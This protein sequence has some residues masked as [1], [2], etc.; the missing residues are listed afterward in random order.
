MFIPLRTFLKFHII[1]ISSSST[2]IRVCEDYSLLR[3][4]VGTTL[5]WQ[6]SDIGAG[7]GCWHC[8][9]LASEERLLM[10]AGW[11]ESCSLT[12]QG[13]HWLSALHRASWA[14]RGK[15]LCSL[16]TSLPTYLSFLITAPSQTLS[17][18]WKTY[19]HRENT[20]HLASLLQS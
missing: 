3:V 4:E 12:K 16:D 6:S 19:T 11:D 14:A 8:R 9:Q 7:N 13:S 5:K 17:I 18:N 1:L 15:V 2:Y 20:K 10:P